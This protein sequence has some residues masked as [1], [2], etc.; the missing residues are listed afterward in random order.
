MQLLTGNTDTNTGVVR[1]LTPPVVASRLRI[2]P[3]SVYAR[4]MCVRAE[5]YG[6]PHT[7]EW[8]LMN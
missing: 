3:F 6:C 5:V 7:G 2:V 1:E 4:T 8:S